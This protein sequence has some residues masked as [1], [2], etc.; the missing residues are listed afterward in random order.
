MVRRI[1]IDAVFTPEIPEPKITMKHKILGLQECYQN[2]WIVLAL[3]KCRT[4]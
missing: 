1:I 4:L 3:L 2:V